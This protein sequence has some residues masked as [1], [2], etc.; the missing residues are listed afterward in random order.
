VR[1]VDLWTVPVVRAGEPVASV[2]RKL[3]QSDVAIPLLVDAEGHPLGWLSER[4]LTGDAVR[5]DLRSGPDPVVELDDILRDA[6]SDL[7]G[8]E[9]LYGPVV[10]ARGVVQGVLSIELLAHLIAAGRLEDVPSAAELAASGD[11]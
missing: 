5:E 9:A 2:R 3:E 10:D 4:A 11:D 7:L 8:Q 1:D 6:L